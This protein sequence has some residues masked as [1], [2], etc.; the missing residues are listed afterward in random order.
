[1]DFKYL[2]LTFAHPN[3]YPI[4]QNSEKPPSTT[5]VN[6]RS[7]YGDILNQGQEGS[8]SAFS[9]LQ[10]R[11]ALR[12]QSGLSWID[13]SEQAQYYEE[14]KLQN[15]VNSDTGATLEEALQI[16]EELGVM[17]EQYDPYGPQT[18]VVD[19]PDDKWN[20][21]LELNPAQVQMIN[22]ANMLADTLDALA[23]GHP[24]FFGFL[25]YSELESAQV[26]QTGVLPMPSA[27]SRVMGGHAVN[28]IGDDPVNERILVLNQWGKNWGIKTPTDL[29]GCFWMPYNYYADCC[30]G[31]YVGLPDRKGIAADGLKPAMIWV[32]SPNYDAGRAGQKVLAIV[33]HIMDGTLVGTD[34]WFQ[35]PNAQASA[36]FGVGK[37]GEIHQYVDINNKAWANGI[38]NRPDWP[39]LI[40]GVNPNL[41]TVSIEHEGNSGDALTEAQYQSSLALHRWLCSELGITPGTDTIIGHNRIDSV[42]RTNCPGNGFPWSRLFSDLEG[43]SFEMDVCVV[44]F[45]A[46]DYSI[47]MDIADMHG[48]CA[49]F[50]R[51]GSAAV[52]PDAK[53]A[54]KVFNVGGPELGWSNEVYMS[55]NKALDTVVAVANAYSSGKLG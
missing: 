17:P 54:A 52:H 40:A 13:P 48:G 3:S 22:P 19:P 12:K 51:N 46:K 27:G 25:V 14:R 31:A 21:S 50:C 8:C 55:G 30:M 38:V 49:M 15:T 45:T 33:D 18:F 32:G 7:L 6:L 20:T 28:A 42:N 36:H 1:M 34:S 39:L 10:W 35:N 5:T 4:Y 53:K 37:N 29:E 23:N 44:Y 16:L 11:G 43:G 9:A 24:V 26:A 47:A 2:P 41:Y